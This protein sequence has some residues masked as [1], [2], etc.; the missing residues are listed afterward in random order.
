MTRL[1][2]AD[3]RVRYGFSYR[4]IAN[5]IGDR[6][7]SHTYISLIEKGSKPLTKELEKR[8]LSAI[9]RADE[10]RAKGEL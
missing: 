3:I 9:Y 4:Q 8:I 6:G 1:E 2:L 5:E 7:L 10:K